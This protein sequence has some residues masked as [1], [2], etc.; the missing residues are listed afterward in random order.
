MFRIP[1]SF[2]LLGRRWRVKRP[3]T[4]N[5]AGDE[6]LGSCCDPAR[7][8]EVRRDLSGDPALETFIHESIHAGFPGGLVSDE[9]EDAICYALEKPML[10]AFRALTAG[11][12]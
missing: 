7:E 10:D 9:V 2:V 4:V 12:R 3:V 6:C 1:S 8:I 5:V 11:K